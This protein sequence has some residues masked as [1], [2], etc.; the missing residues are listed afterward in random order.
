M[1]PPPNIRCRAVRKRQLFGVGNAEFDR[2]AF[3]GGALPAFFQQG[4]HVVGRHHARKTACRRQRGIAIA[5]GDVEHGFT[6][7]DVGRLGQ[8]FADDLQGHAD[9]GKIAAGPD[10]LL[11]LLDRREVRRAVGLGLRCGGGGSGGGA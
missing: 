7:P 4:R 9:H 8:G 10:R 2:Q 11:H 6:G 1:R 5:G 3:G